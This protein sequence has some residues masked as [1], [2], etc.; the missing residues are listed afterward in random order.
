MYIPANYENINFAAGTYTPSVVKSCDNESYSFWERA[1]FQRALSVIDI[2]NRPEKW[3]GSVYD[4][5]R[6][7][8]FRYGYV[9]CFKNVKFGGSVFQPATLNGYDFYYDFTEAIINNPKFSKTLEI[10]KDCEILKLTPDYLGIWDIIHYYAKRLSEID[11]AIDMSLINSKYSLIFGAAGK[12]GAKFL[13]K[14]VD[15]VNKGEPAVIFDSKYVLPLDP[16][17][18]EPAITDYSRKDIKNTYLGTDLLKDFQT[19]LNNFDCEIGIPTIPYQKAE[20]MVESEAESRQLDATSRSKIWV[21]TLN[22]S[23]K[24]VNSLLGTNM[25]AIHNYDTDNGTEVNEGG[26]ENE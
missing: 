18:K 4:F 6:W 1:L 19:V 2:E 11:P 3:N 12:S 16:T 21:D 9:A 13:Q 15:S 23:L 7:C 5:L 14:V 20:R 26:V 8:L 22:T 25:R 24:A 10:H 17:S